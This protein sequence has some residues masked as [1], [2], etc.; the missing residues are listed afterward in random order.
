MLARI[1]S[2]VLTDLTLLDVSY[3]AGRERKNDIHWAQKHLKRLSL[4]RKANQLLNT[5][6]SYEISFK[7][8]YLDTIILLYNSTPQ[9]RP[10]KNGYKDVMTF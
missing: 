8:V 9:L 7:K 6:A 3:N 10:Y 1:S 2:H 4:H 5:E